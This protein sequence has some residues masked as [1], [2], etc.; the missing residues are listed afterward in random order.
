MIRASH[1]RAGSALAVVLAMVTAASADVPRL[2]SFQGKIAG[3]TTGPVNLNVRLSDA[4]VL[5]I[6]W[7]SEDHLNVPLNNGVFSIMIGSQT[8][9][10]VP[11]LPLDVDELYVSVSVNGAPEL[12]PRTRI[13]MVPYAAKANKSEVLVVPNTFDA[14]ATVDSSG[15]IDVENHLNFALDP[16]PLI[17]AGHDNTIPT[18]MWIAHSESFPNWGLQYRDY[19]SAGYGSD[20][21]EIVG[22]DPNVPR[23]SFEAFTGKMIMTSQAGDQN[24]EIRSRYSS[25]VPAAWMTLRDAGSSRVAIAAE[26]GVTGAGGMIDLYNDSSVRTISLRGQD[27]VGTGGELIM[28]DAN[29]DTTVDIDS[30]IGSGGYIAVLGDASNSSSAIM[31]ATSSGGLIQLRNSSGSTTITL[32]AETGGDGRI[33]TQELAITGGSDLSE[34]FDIR[35]D[36][37]EPGMVVCIDPANPG[38]L[39]VCTRANDRTVAGIISGA[40]NVKPGMIMGQVGTEA[41]GKHPVALTGRVWVKCETNTG[42]IVPGDLLTTSAVPGHAM[43]VSDHD[44]ARGAIIGKA[45]TSLDSGTGLVL[46]LV[47]LQ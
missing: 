16:Y 19:S 1:M 47:S 22:G 15:N 24:V 11:D 41:D 31:Q 17:T 2:I 45:M 43:K 32:D 14:V 21:V 44:A 46:V 25:T 29:G 5:G 33:T 12:T 30:D 23:F 38:D 9:G 42:A 6:L 18:R 7:F 37:V 26:S 28:T 8:V 39:A 40:G 34:Q 4:P 35:G 13:G 10:G 20:A 27:S 36:A 3:E